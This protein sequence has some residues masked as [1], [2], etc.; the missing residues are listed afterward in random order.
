[1]EL[2]GDWVATPSF[3][4][5]NRFVLFLSYFSHHI[6]LRLVAFLVVNIYIRCVCVFEKYLWCVISW[7]YMMR[8]KNGMHCLWFKIDISLENGLKNGFFSVFRYVLYNIACVQHNDSD[9][10]CSN[11]C[12]SSH[13][14]FSSGFSFHGSVVRR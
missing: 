2:T 6:E 5:G 11:G 7:N 1:M 13:F 4:H 8:E 14:P 12:F 9:V 3:F 10:V